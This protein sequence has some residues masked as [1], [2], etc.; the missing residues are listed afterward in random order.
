VF[1]YPGEAVGRAQS[2]PLGNRCE[3]IAAPDSL[4]A[5]AI[6]EDSPHGGNK[7]APACEEDAVHGAGID[8][9]IF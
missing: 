9:G 8:P 3:L 2:K 7:R 4:I 5:K 6:R 1:S